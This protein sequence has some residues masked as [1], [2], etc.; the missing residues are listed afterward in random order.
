MS[1][2]GSCTRFEARRAGTGSPFELLAEDATWTIVGNFI[3]SR[4]FRTGRVP[5]RGYPPIHARMRAA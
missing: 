5:R 2:K 4:M 3:V 1:N